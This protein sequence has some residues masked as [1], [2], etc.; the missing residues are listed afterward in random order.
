MSKAL[1]VRRCLVAAYFLAV[2]WIVF[3]PAQ[4]DTTGEVPLLGVLSW[5][6]A[7][8]IPE[9]LVNYST[10]EFT[11]NVMMFVPMGLIFVWHLPTRKWWLSPLAGLACSAA[12]E[13][14]QGLFLPDRVSDVRDL[15]S[16]TLGALLGALFGLLVR[17]KATA[18]A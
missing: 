5:L 8:G 12:I 13:L 16:N 14:I 18:D 15:A 1:L 4:V 2:A 17:G 7:H 6:N 10:V 3:W 9:W 11:A